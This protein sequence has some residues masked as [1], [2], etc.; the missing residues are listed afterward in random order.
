MEKVPIFMK[1]QKFMVFPEEAE[2]YARS[3]GAEPYDPKKHD[4]K[5]EQKPRQA[6]Q[7]KAIPKAA[8][9]KAVFKKKK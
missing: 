6:P 4:K 7:N 3:H 8:G 1:G 5:E 2:N 9:N